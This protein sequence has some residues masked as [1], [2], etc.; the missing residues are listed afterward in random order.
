M[1][2]ENFTDKNVHFVLFF[3]ELCLLHTAPAPVSEDHSV[4]QA[5]IG[6]EKQTNI[7]TL[8]DR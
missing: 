5:C 3:S 7:I 6:S 4:D 8:S 1:M 2:G